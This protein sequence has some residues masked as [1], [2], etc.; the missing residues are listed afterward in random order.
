MDDTIKN[1]II[2]AANINGTSYEAV[3]RGD[4]FLR[5]VRAKRMVVA[6]LIS[7]GMSMIDVAEIFNL[8]G[9]HIRYS[10]KKHEEENRFDKVYKQTYYKLRKEYERITE[11]G[12]NSNRN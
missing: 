7:Y 2:F 12:E 8:S 11:H 9:G 10:I 5:P 4:R 3:M 1:I 6:L